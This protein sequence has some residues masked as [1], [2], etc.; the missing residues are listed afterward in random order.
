MNISTR[1]TS[2]LSTAAV[3]L[4]MAGCA[5]EPPGYQSSGG[6]TVT[7]K[8]DV[9]PATTDARHRA[10]SPQRPGVNPQFVPEDKIGDLRDRIEYLEAEVGALEDRLDEQADAYEQMRK[11]ITGSTRTNAYDF[12]TEDGNESDSD[13]SDRPEAS[14]DE[15]PGDENDGMAASDSI[16][17]VRRDTD[18]LAARQFYSPGD[19]NASTGSSPSYKVYTRSG[20]KSD[21]QEPSDAPAE[22]EASQRE[23]N[24]L[25]AAPAMRSADIEERAR[26]LRAMASQVKYPAWLPNPRKKSGAGAVE[27]LDLSSPGMVTNLATAE[28]EDLTDGEARSEAAVDAA[29]PAPPEEDAGE[30]NVF[31]DFDQAA[32][33]DKVDTFLAAHG[34]ED[35]FVQSKNGVHRIYLGS[36]R[37]EGDAKSR[38]KQIEDKTGFRPRITGGS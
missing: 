13:A 8:G 28:L 4:I 37:Q 19:D 18:A 34:I 36:F 20:E 23:R 6:Y 33:L 3:L 30:F 11:A 29:L 5:N 15:E 1:T 17:D 7:S 26:Q 10:S 31:L 14:T 35:K 16:D 21:P 38:Q 24:A 12:L 9:V 25:I 27:E 22:R 2:F 32:S